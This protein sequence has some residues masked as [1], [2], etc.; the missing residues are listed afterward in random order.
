ME[1]NGLIRKFKEKIQKKKIDSYF[2]KFS[3]K[4]NVTQDYIIET[5]N[6]LRYKNKKGD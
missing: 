5:V 4:H 2:R 3:R 1:N 6:K